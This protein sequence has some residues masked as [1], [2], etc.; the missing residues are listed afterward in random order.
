[1]LKCFYLFRRFTSELVKVAKK[2]TA[3]D[4][5][6]AYVEENRKSNGHHAHAN[7]MAADVMEL[8]LSPKRWVCI[9][10]F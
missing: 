1:V 3:I 9:S 5:I 7:F 4:F 6:D 8:E 10:S 2:V